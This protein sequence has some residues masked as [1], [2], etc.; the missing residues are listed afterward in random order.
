MKKLL[1]LVLLISTAALSQDSQPKPDATPTPSTP[2][3][4]ASKILRVFV[5]GNNATALEVRREMEQSAKYYA[6]HPEKAAKSKFCMVLVDNPKNAAA[7]LSIESAVNGRGLDTNY[8]SSAMLTAADGT[9]LWSDSLGDGSK[10]MDRIIGGS[11]KMNASRLL[12][13]AAK[14]VCK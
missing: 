9:L 10:F 3:T 4:P 13:N 7:T 2:K 11:P 5:A 6:K 14:A 1:L 8:T 12:T